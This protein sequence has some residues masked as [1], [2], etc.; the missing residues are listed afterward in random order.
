MTAAE[1]LGLRVPDE[2]AVTG[3]DD[4]MAARYARLTQARWLWRWR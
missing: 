1:D 4:V 3:W 2:L